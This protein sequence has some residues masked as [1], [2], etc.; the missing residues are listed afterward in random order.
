MW[1]AGQKVLLTI[2]NQPSRKLLIALQ[3]WYQSAAGHCPD[4]AYIHPQVI[5]QAA[6]TAPTPLHLSGFLS[7]P[8]FLLDLPSI[9]DL[10]QAG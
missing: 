9:L 1:K 3:A 2:S 5:Q 10:I 6:L 7:R 8:S 4:E